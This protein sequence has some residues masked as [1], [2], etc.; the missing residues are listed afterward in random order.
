MAPSPLQMAD[1]YGSKWLWFFISA[2]GLLLVS[3]WILG[4][5]GDTPTAHTC[6]CTHTLTQGA[7]GGKTVN[8]VL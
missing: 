6:A 2:S 4:C 7:G 1:L 8:L 3:L 5:R